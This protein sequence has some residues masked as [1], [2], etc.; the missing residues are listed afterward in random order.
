M[1][2]ACVSLK[3]SAA[4]ESIDIEFHC[5]T[6]KALGICGYCGGPPPNNNNNSN[7][8][9]QNPHISKHTL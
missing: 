1:H 7:Y 4:P 8:P 9:Q 5:F 3:S 6:S 2:L